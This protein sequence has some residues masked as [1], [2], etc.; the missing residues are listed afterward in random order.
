MK[1]SVHGD[2]AVGPGEEYGTDDQTPAE[3]RVGQSPR[4][5]E[6]PVQ[7]G[8]NHAPEYQLLGEAGHDQEEGPALSVQFLASPKDEK[9]CGQCQG[10]QA[11]D[12]RRLQ[13]T[14]T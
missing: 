11:S 9:D 10:Q 7:Q 6:N 1:L 14:W 4:F 13:A 12:D 8:L 3:V 2:K 5:P